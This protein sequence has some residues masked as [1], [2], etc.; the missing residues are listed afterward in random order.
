MRTKGYWADLKAPDFQNLPSDTIAILPLGA[1]EQHGDHLPVSVDTT[2]VDTVLARSLTDWHEG[3]N[4]LILPTLS[5]T[6]SNEH[7]DHPGT[8][9]LSARSLLAVLEDIGASVA[10]SGVRR[11]AL[12]NGHGGNTAILEIACRELRVQH[13]MITAHCSW[14]GFSDTDGLIPAEDGTHDLH[15]GDIETSAMLAARGD[16][17]DMTRATNQHPKS[18]NWQSDLRWIGLN[19][20]AARPGWKIGDLSQ[21]GVCG[22]ASGATLEKGEAMIASAARNFA[23][24]LSEFARFDPAL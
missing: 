18:R 5:V 10:R 16:L 21:G 12:F 19:G 7:L 9:T 3:T 20:Q 8:L 15:A 1:T 14:F 17:V 13:G 23:D 22:D 4:A 6:K 24:F 11:L 2:L